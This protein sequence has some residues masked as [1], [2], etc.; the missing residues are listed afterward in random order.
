MSDEPTLVQPR[1]ADRIPLGPL[2]PRD[3][4]WLAALDRVPV[5]GRVEW[6]EAMVARVEAINADRAR[7]V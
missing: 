6:V 5:E 4:L 1:L 7:A 2:G 3:I